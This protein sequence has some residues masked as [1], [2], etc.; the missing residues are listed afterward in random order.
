MLTTEGIKWMNE[1]SKDMK[2]R[3]TKYN[4]L[5]ETKGGRGKK[6]KQ[7]IR[8]KD[9]QNIILL[10]YLQKIDKN[11]LKVFEDHPRHIKKLSLI[12]I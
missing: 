1:A 5:S 12:H 11:K 10:V 9:F 4:Q 3:I 8:K 2:K 7:L 6:R